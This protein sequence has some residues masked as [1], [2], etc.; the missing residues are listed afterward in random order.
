VRGPLCGG[1]N[2]ARLEHHTKKAA[3]PDSPFTRLAHPAGLTSGPG[4]GVLDSD[5]MGATLGTP[6][7][8]VTA[9]IAECCASPNLGRSIQVRWEGRDVDAE[10]ARGVRLE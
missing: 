1:S 10:S 6:S 5:L 3:G 7:P 9:W 4:G 8:G 2:G